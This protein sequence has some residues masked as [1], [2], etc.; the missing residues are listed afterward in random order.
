MSTLSFSFVKK[1]T[2]LF[3]LHNSKKSE[4]NTLILKQ[5]FQELHSRFSDYQRVFTDGSKDGIK[6]GC[7][8]VSKHAQQILR[9][10]DG[11]S[12]FTVEAKQSTWLWI[13]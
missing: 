5:N 1:P 10:P 2:V 3:D 4:S 7:A 9:L 8:N 13:I 6:V 12:V 11:S